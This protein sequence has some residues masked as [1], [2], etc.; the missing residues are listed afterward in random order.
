[1]FF[2]KIFGALSVWRWMAEGI[3]YQKKLKIKYLEKREQVE[4]AAWICWFLSTD[5]S[6]GKRASEMGRKDTRQR[7]VAGGQCSVKS[8]RI[9]GASVP[10][11]QVRRGWELKLLILSGAGDLAAAGLS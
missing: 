1:M 10:H 7:T 11:I 8:R 9:I 2:Q 5:C 3:F 4:V 6:T